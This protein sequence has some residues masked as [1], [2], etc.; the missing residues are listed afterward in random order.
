MSQPPT[1]PILWAADNRLFKLQEFIPHVQIHD[2]S[3][4]GIWMRG[5]AR[6]LA[7]VCPGRY[8][9]MNDRGLDYHDC[10][11]RQIYDSLIRDHHE[12]V[13]FTRGWVLAFDNISDAVL[14]K[15]SH[16]WA[17]ANQWDDLDA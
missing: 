6:W 12:A 4:A 1:D 13:M 8:K 2:T 10:C 7:D 9:L 14:F 17:E 11:S 3:V 5:V 15:L 16:I